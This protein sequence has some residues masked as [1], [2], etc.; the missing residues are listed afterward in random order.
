MIDRRDIVIIA[1][2]T[3]FVSVM[4]LYGMIDFELA[5]YSTTDVG[6]ITASVSWII[7]Y[8]YCEG[9]TW[10]EAGYLSKIVMGLS[11]I[12]LLGMEFTTQ[13]PNLID[14]LPLGAWIPVLIHMFSYYRTGVYEG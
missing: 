12:L 2:G 3:L 11:W 9:D 5:G 10:D 7:G 1:G 8:V 13:V 6:F 4:A 14:A